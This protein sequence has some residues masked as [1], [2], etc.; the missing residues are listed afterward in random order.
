L[1]LT[2]ASS[3]P[4]LPRLS[5]YIQGTLKDI[6]GTFKDIQGTF[7]GIFAF[8]AAGDF[9]IPGTAKALFSPARV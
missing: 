4:A 2:E 9:I 3:S 5:S 8:G 1:G 7:K 6:Q